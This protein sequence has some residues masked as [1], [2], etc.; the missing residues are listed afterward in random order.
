MNLEVHSISYTYIL[1]RTCQSFTQSLEHPEERY[2]QN[3]KQKQQGKKGEE[4]ERKGERKKSIGL[5]V[6]FVN[7]LKF[8][9]IYTNVNNKLLPLER[10]RKV[11][12][13]FQR[14]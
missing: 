2:L 10:K 1:T 4:K 5:I 7:V 3:R 13:R 9:C 8:Y 6:T 11:M 14:V 12:H